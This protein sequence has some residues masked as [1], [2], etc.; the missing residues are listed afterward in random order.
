MSSD[1]SSISF[2]TLSLS[3]SS[4][5]SLVEP[6]WVE[7]F[8][9]VGKYNN[10]LQSYMDENASSQKVF[11]A[12][13]KF[14]SAYYELK[15]RLAFDSSAI[16]SEQLAELKSMHSA[17]KGRLSF[18][19]LADRSSSV[20]SQWAA[21]KADHAKFKTAYEKISSPNGSKFET[22]YPQYIRAYASLK[23][24]VKALQ[25]SLEKSDPHQI[26]LQKLLTNIQALHKNVLKPVPHQTEI[27]SSTP[28]PTPTPTTALDDLRSL[29]RRAA[30]TMYGTQFATDLTD[31][32]LYTAL[33][34]LA[35]YSNPSQD[36][37]YY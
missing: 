23:F 20:K 1:F 32:I 35:I 4:S 12:Y 8:A 5:S 26:V 10:K 9:K 29:G 22:D 14:H 16:G 13:S 33:C 34:A 15:P 6:S 11:S 30:T 27:D 18:L 7:G 31:L 28:V 25:S 37:N 36:N 21:C 17:I 24:K 3:P 19:S 2:E